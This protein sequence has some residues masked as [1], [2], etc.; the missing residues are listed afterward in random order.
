MDRSQDHGARWVSI[1]EWVAAR[2]ALELGPTIP[3]PLGV[4]TPASQEEILAMRR[5]KSGPGVSHHTTLPPH[6]R[7]QRRRT[8]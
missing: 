5:R 1:D 6:L 3:Q 2:T 8:A 4:M 7:Q